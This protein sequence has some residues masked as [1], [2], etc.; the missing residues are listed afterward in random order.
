MPAM[1]LGLVTITT[2]TALAALGGSAASAADFYQ[3]KTITVIVGYAPGGGVDATARAITRHFGRFIPGQP[4]IV[5]QNMEGAAGIV[6]VNH[7]ERRT[8]PDG[9]TLAV[10]GRSWYIEAV[11]KRP[12]V[13]FDPVKLTYIGSPGSLTSAAFI[14]SDTTGIKTFDD[15]KVHSKPVLFGGLGPGTP[16]AMVPNLLAANGLP[17][18]VVLGYVSTARIL[19]AMEQGELDGFF[20]VGN[21]LAARPDLFSKTAAVAQTAP[22]RPGVP[23]VRDVIRPDHRQVYDLVTAPDTFGVPMVGPPGMPADVTE[24]LRKAYIAMA[25]DKGYQADAEKVE[26]PVGHPIDGARLQAMMRDLAA[27]ATPP[28]VAEFLRLSKPK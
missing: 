13:T 12:G 26:L 8:A 20:T 1:R 3:G 9:L 2:A 6:S 5:V 24:I 10:P 21:A 18:K 19:L 27:N 16:T 11:V 17:V 4:T 25:K 22:I 28:V 15:L 23:L 7:L 14:R